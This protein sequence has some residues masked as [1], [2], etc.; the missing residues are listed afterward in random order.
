MHRRARFF[1]A[2]LVTLVLLTLVA[3]LLP[4]S[5][6]QAAQEYSQ[7]QTQL[8]NP[9]LLSIFINNFGIAI[10]GFLPFVGAIYEGFVLFNTG[11][12]VAAIGT[13]KGVPAT[14]LL[15]VSMTTPFF[16]MEYVSYSIAISAAAFLIVSIQQRRFRM[17]FKYFLLQI[18]LVAGLLLAAVFIEIA[19]VA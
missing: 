6:A 15:A 14:Y 12:A 3:V 11:L 17:E 19:Y 16:W 2:T 8:A 7:L 4:I 10:I 13:T 1:V 5:K 18:A 9:T